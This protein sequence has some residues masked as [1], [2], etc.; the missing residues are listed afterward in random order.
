MRN[1]E[2]KEIKLLGQ[3]VR[4]EARI[5][6]LAVW[7]STFLICTTLDIKNNWYDTNIGRKGN[8]IC[9]VS[10]NAKSHFKLYL[11]F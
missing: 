5:W 4:D 1:L 10:P 8:N 11:L 6:V 9:R 2:H 7:T 3:R